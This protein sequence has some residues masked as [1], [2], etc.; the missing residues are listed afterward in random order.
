MNH[1][2]NRVGRTVRVGRIFALAAISTLALVFIMASLA[3]PLQATKSTAGTLAKA[4]NA[5]KARVAV[6][7]TVMATGDNTFTPAVITVT[8]GDTVQWVRMG[9]FHNVVSDDLFR[10]SDDPLGDPSSSWSTVSFTFTEAGTFDYYCEPHQG[11]GMEGQVIV[12]PAEEPEETATPTTTVTMTVTST[13]T[14]TMTPTTMTP[15]PTATPVMTVTPVM[16]ATPVM[17]STPVMTTTPV[18]TDP[19]A[20]ETPTSI[21]T[22]PTVPAPMT[23]TVTVTDIVI[24]EVFYHG[25]ATG[26]A[27][28]SEDWFE[29]Q[30]LGGS[31]IDITNWWVCIRR[32]YETFANLTILSGDLMLSPGEIVVVQSPIDLL[33]ES[34]FS[35]Y[36]GENG[37]RPDFGNPDH[38]VD[39]LQWGSPINQ[40][41]ADVAVQKGIW[42]ETAMDTYSFVPAAE[43][44]ESIAL[45]GGAG[46]SAGNY[47][48]GSPS[49]GNS[50]P[51]PLE[52]LLYYL[53]FVAPQE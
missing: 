45:V 9:G 30:N 43:V 22:V 17:T 28:A 7:H 18:M 47:A 33:T 44:G 16:T 10:L 37:A 19:D 13:V 1:K 24:S 11:L 21:P 34:D 2:K 26:Q 6:T 53:P 8:V 23:G 31:T 14:V 27:G 20:T 15:M 51:A 50:N 29:L 3:E 32:S 5:M 41:R 35:I 4:Q 39:F 25:G 52:D 36:V 40:G 42:T 12:V 48:N 38:M 49:Q 46:D